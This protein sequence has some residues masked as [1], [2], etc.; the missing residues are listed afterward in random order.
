MNEY[1][2]QNFYF[3]GCWEVWEADTSLRVDVAVAHWCVEVWASIYMEDSLVMAASRCRTVHQDTPDE[4]GLLPPAIIRVVP[5]YKR[6]S[7]WVISCELMKNN[8]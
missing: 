6:V 2:Y 1:D 3:S 4:E 5:L 8:F 7:N